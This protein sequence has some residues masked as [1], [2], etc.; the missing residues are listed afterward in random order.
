MKFNNPM[1]ELCGVILEF[2]QDHPLNRDLHVV[3][4][5]LEQSALIDQ[6]EKKCL[7]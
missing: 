6:L 3:V 1:Q 5:S 2:Y 7:R 4:G